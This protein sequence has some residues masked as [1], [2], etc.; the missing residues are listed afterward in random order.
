MKIG[1]VC[2]PTLGGSGVLATELGHELANRGH[3]VHFITFEQPFRLR[4]ETENLFFHEVDMNQYDLIRYPDYALALA[5]KIAAV[6]KEHALDILHVHYAIPHATSAFLARQLLGNH[7]P[8]VVT[9]LHGTDITAVG[10]DP[11][12]FEIVKFS[13]E[14]SDGVTA[15]SHYLESKT[16]EYFGIQKPIEVI[17]NFF[18]PRPEIGFDVYLRQTYTPN[19]EK[20]M[21]HASNFRPVK[22]VADVI[23]VF[24]KVQ[25]QIP[26]K[27]LL[28]GTGVGIEDTRAAV[29]E[30][31]LEDHVIF[32]GKQSNIDE[33]IASSDVFLLPSSQESF[34]L[35]ALEAMA[36]GVP[37]VAT[38]VG[39]L[40]E[41]I[42]N[43]D[44]G[45]L[46]GVGDIDAMAAK[47][48][49]IMSNPERAKQ[50]G[51]RG[52]QRAREAFTVERILP[53]YE[54]FYQQ[55]L[56]SVSSI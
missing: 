12:Y 52:R 2:Y 5:V 4:L 51:A 16:H 26:A 36:Y 29:Q 18:T 53:Q 35:V 54:A 19:G 25:K 47:A 10:R 48:I 40:P 42:E 28:I 32:V 8:A 14:Q 39:G 34:G 56:L 44:T 13:I 7:R 15:V 55:A 1:I 11:A 41:V 31:E 33:L 27:L 17:Y 23:K 46:V 6:S 20:L 30:Y 37:V 3:Q 45:F 38:N 24:A 50:M 49:E 43:G 9:T 21:V 22:R